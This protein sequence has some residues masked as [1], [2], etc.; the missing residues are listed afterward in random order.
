MTETQIQKEF[1]RGYDI[2]LVRVLLA[3]LPRL[4]E[5][6]RHQ[7]YVVEGWEYFE[8]ERAQGR[9]VIFVGSHYGVSRLFPCWLALQG[10]E[11]LSIELF[12]Y[13][14]SV[15]RTELRPKT[16]QVRETHDQFPA[17]LTLEALRVLRAGGCV[18]TAG[19]H[20]TSGEQRSRPFTYG[21]GEVTFPL[22]MP[23]LSLLS[24][25]AMIPYFCTLDE[26]GR[27][28]VEL[29][30]VIRPRCRPEGLTPEQ[31][32][33]EIEWLCEQSARVHI[34]AVEQ[35]PGNLF[36]NLPST[37]RIASRGGSKRTRTARQQRHPPGQVRPDKTPAEPQ[38]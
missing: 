31:R 20:A 21:G 35:A 11:V 22:G 30:P 24:G 16:L 28:R 23:T 34:A 38:E 37:K 3:Q 26:S 10:V 17:R 25:A 29:K 18:H 9:P 4:S 15:T 36:N 33:E 8:N 1:Q 5:G 32:Q 2:I 12:D 6:V 27:V 19:D 7:R 13:L 14:K